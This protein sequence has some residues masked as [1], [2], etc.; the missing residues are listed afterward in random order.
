MKY[1]NGDGI[2]SDE[3]VDFSEWTPTTST[4]EIITTSSNEATTSTTEV[5]TSTTEAITSTTTEET[6]ISTPNDTDDDYTGCGINQGCFGYPSNCVA[7]KSCTIL[8][9]FVQQV[10]NGGVDFNLISS[11]MTNRY[12]RYRQIFAVWP[13]DH[14]LESYQK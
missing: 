2:I 11:S 6:T 4:T 5:I 10:E 1:H 13:E 14:N 8:L 7:S 3:K 9:T 12:R